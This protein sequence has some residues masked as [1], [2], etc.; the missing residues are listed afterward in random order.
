MTARARRRRGG[1]FT[2]LEVM[3][4]LVLL[5]FALVVL[6]KSSARS[7]QAARSAQMLGVV[8]DLARGKMH[9]LE[10]MLLKEGF[11]DS[12]QTEEGRPFDDEGWPNVKYSYKIQEIDLPSF[13]Q[14]QAMATAR[15]S[16][17]GAG[18][19]AGSGSGSGDGGEADPLASFNDSLLG[20]AMM[21]ELGG[22]SGIEGAA[23]AAMMQG[24]YPMFREILK[25]SIRKVTLTV[26]WEIS[27]SPRELTTVAFFTD[28]AA[29]DKVIQGLG[30]QELPDDPSAGGGGTDAGGRTPR[31]P[32]GRGS[33]SG[34]GER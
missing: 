32:G 20:G 22:E 34:G 7:I 5:G 4:G 6:I 1:G 23:G 13:E 9:D 31:A 3:L 11:T 15:A 12:D 19:G 29:M 17:S 2:L 25:V 21:S 27:G 24:M 14:L 18:S 26:E 28:A 33:A 8:T 16:G 30:M 10:E